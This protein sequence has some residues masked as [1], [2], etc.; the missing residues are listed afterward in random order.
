MKVSNFKILGIYYT[1]HKPQSKY[2][3]TW[4]TV[5]SSFFIQS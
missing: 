3:A 1:P 2:E 4:P 5:C